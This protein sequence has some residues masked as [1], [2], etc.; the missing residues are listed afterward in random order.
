MIMI[1]KLIVVII[2]L[3]L[4]APVYAANQPVK[5]ETYDITVAP[6]KPWTMVVKFDFKGRTPAERQK[7]HYLAYIGGPTLLSS[8]LLVRMYVE[9]STLD[10]TAIL[11]SLTEKQTAVITAPGNNWYLTYIPD[12]GSALLLASGT[13]KVV[14]P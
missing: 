9:K 6:G 2:M 7:D 14:Q 5:A 8:R 11:L 3:I 13:V 12:T 10:T 1:M 4:G